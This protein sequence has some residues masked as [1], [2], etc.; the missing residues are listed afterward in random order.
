MN[1]PLTPDEVMQKVSAGRPYILLH[2]LPGA[3]APAD[4]S[5]AKQLQMGHLQHLFSLEQEGHSC[6]FGPIINDPDLIGII[7]FKTNDRAVIEELMSNDP[8]INGGYLRYK[9]FDLFSIPGQ[10]L[11]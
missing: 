4:E 11:S 2:F 9:L 10:S 8:Y 5:L 6:M 7:I 1:Q 3:P